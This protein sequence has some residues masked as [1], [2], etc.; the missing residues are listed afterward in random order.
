VIDAGGRVYFAKDARLSP[1]K[2]AAMYPRM[3]EF[4]AIKNRID[5]DHRLTSDLA[6]RLQLS[7][8]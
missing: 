4:L 7:G 2:V 3:H 8:K 6:R 1:D 5:P